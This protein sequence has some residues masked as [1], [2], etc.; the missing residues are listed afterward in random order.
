MKKFV[1][2]V[3][4]VCTL[5]VSAIAFASPWET[6]GMPDVDM[7]GNTYIPYCESS[8][9]DVRCVAATFDDGTILRMDAPTMVIKEVDVTKPGQT[10][11]NET[12]G[13]R[14]VD[15]THHERCS[16]ARDKQGTTYYTYHMKDGSLTR[17]A[18]DGN[19]T[20]TWISRLAAN[21][22]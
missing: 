16:I 7:D 2:F 20:I 15:S 18:V 4:F 9:G 8:S 3:I 12:V 22:D 19:M 13:E 11:G 6:Q 1:T 14:F 10:L 5:I 17:Y 21:L